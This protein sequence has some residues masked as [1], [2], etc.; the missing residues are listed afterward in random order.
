[1]ISHDR[2]HVNQCLQDIEKRYFPD[3]VSSNTALGQRDL[4]YLID[5]MD[6]KK[7]IQ[8]SLSTM[9]RLWKNEYS[10]LP[11]ISTLNALVSLLGHENW[12]SYRREQL[13]KIQKPNKTVAQS[14]RF[15]KIIPVVAVLGTIVLMYF[16]I[17]LIRGE[18]EMEVPKDVVFSANKTVAFNVPN[19]VIFSYDLTQTKADSFFIQRS[20]NPMHKFRIDPQKKTFSQIYYYPGFHWA[21]LI[22][23][24]S[25][26]Q[27]E[28]IHI[29]TNGWLATAK[30]NPMQQIPKYAATPEIQS[31]GKLT[32]QN[33]TREALGFG[34]NQNLILSYFNVRDFKGLASDAFVLETKVRFENTKNLTCPFLEVKWIDEKD[35]SW[36]GIIDKGCESNLNLKLGDNFFMGSENDFSLLGANMDEW[37]HLKIISNNNIV[38][39]YIND[40]LCLE[41]QFTGAQGD[42]MGLIFTFTGSGSLD[43]VYLKDL[44]GNTR[45]ADDFSN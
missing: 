11:H 26:I 27:K 35:A 13:S 41:N 18:P 1:M 4:Q 10:S 19:S 8:I 24:D 21:R 38:Q 36:V 2:A 5:L 3:K 44:E 23:N 20:W 34:L 43:Y 39:F 32:L 31:D 42:I 16:L 40:T 28:R 12:N 9:K 17:S 15:T 6:E 22:A 45:Y 25:I 7:N 33:T 14:N 37:Q 30:S 29:Q